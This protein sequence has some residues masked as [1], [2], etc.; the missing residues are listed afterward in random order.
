MRTETCSGQ[1]IKIQSVKYWLIRTIFV[2]LTDTLPNHIKRQ[3]SSF[4]R[5]CSQFAMALRHW[6]QSLFRR[7]LH[8]LQKEVNKN[9]NESERQSTKNGSLSGSRPTRL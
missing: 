1:A 7:F 2:V 3:F 8:S 4:E 5:F 6:M 9:G